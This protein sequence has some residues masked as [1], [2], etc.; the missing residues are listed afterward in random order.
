[1]STIGVACCESFEQSSEEEIFE[2]SVSLLKAF[3]I[4]VFHS[5]MKQMKV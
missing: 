1:M 5:K 4:A 2:G 3:L